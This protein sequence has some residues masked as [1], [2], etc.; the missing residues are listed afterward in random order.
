MHRPARRENGEEWEPANRPLQQEWQV[1]ASQKQDSVDQ[2][3]S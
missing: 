3:H 1:A 2:K